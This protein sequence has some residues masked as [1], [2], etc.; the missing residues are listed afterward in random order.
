MARRDE[1]SK[2]ARDNL[3][4]IYSRMRPDAAAAQLMA[5]DLETA[6][7]VL[8]KLEPRSASLILNE[9]EAGYAARLTGTIAAAASSAGQAAP[10]TPRPEEK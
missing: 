7:A 6:A 9:M 10:A 3:V 4:S 5:I 8:T 2:K 1:F